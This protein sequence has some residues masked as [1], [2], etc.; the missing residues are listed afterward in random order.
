[1]TDLAMTIDDI[2]STLC[3]ALRDV[4]TGRMEPGVGTSMA[5]IA[6]T[7]TTIRTASEIEARIATLEAQVGVGTVRRFS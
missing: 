6:R 2:D 4:S 3:Q 5:T 7:I 1:M